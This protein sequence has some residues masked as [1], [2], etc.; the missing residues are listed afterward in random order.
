MWDARRILKDL[1]DT[2]RRRKILTAFWRYAD[3]TQKAIV[4][5]QLARA[6]KFRE[7]TL[8][9]LPVEKKADLFASRIGS[10]EFDQYLE[11]AL[12]QYHTHQQTEMMAA[13]LDRWQIPHENGSIE[14]DEYKTPDTEAVR[15]AV[16]ELQGQYDKRDI[17]LYLA[18]A[19]LLMDGGWRESVEPVIAE[20]V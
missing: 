8:R 14:A 15:S 6:L 12:M 1:A 18:S 11:L 10:P 9:K 17:A 20:L 7:E 5:A 3:N 19:A 2:D 16:A 13:F 4:T